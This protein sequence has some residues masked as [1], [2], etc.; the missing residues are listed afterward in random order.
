MLETNI[1]NVL[2]DNIYN[3]SSTV[4]FVN[5][6]YRELLKGGLMKN[7]IRVMKGVFLY[8]SWLRSIS[9]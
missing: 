5:D 2:Y 4:L 9:K 6:T 7:N 1:Y 3:Y 8:R